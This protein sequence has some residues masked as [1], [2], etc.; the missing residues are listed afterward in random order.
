ME[1][2][3]ALIAIHTVCD[4][5]LQ[6]DS[7]VEDRFKNKVH[8]SALLKHITVHFIAFLVFLSVL[9][10]T[11][12]QVISVTVFMAISHYLI[13]IW[14]SYQPRNNLFFIIDQSLHFIVILFCWLLLKPENLQA[15]FE[16]LDK[17]YSFKNISILL[18][19]LLACKPISI[20]MSLGLQKYSAQVDN[21]L[22]GLQTAGKWIGYIERCL[23]ITFI[24]I[25][26]FTAI[27]FLLAAKTIFRLGDLSKSKDMKLTEYMMIGT[28]FSFSAAIALGLLAK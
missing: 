19:Y 21:H 12:K 7:W 8:S 9:D 15:I 16:T 10:F 25:N 5:Y 4:F 27:G 28:L 6:P 18:A 1:L 13:D 20:L 23:I 26:Q 2:L 14:K 11:L 24:L 22:H 3:L 17:L